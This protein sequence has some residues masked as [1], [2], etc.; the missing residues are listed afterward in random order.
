MFNLREPREH[1]ETTVRTTA[2]SS[3]APSTILSHTLTR[4]EE[5]DEDAVHESLNHREGLL[6]NFIPSGYGER[7]RSDIFKQA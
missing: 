4:V 3:V 1:S 7:D 6:R 2:A 5:V